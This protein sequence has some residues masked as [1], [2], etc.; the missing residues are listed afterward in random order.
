MVSSRGVMSIPLRS[1]RNGFLSVRDEHASTVSLQS[2]GTADVRFS[3]PQAVEPFAITSLVET[4]NPSFGFVPDDEIG[5][6]YEYKISNKE[7][8]YFATDKSTDTI[9]YIY[10]TNEA[11]YASLMQSIS[12]I[13]DNVYIGNLYAAIDEETLR[14]NNIQSIVQ[15]F[16]GF[17]PVFPSDYDYLVI[18]IEDRTDISIKEQFPRFLSFLEGKVKPPNHP[19]GQPAGNVLIH[20]QHGSS[21]SGTFVILY[22]MYYHA[23]S[24]EDALQY[25]RRKRLG[26]FPN[27]SFQRQLKE[28]GETWK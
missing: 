14:S 18:S 24:F 10:Y 3:I 6:L 11:F 9:S 28:F 4:T 13:I 17:D 5:K 27:P 15:V 21:R 22:L 19:T 20:C 26:I 23:M 16:D 2:E 25:A 8:I 12:H 1:S 7:C